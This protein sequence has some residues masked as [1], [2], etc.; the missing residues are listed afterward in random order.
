MF[1]GESNSV[2]VRR[3]VSR[4]HVKGCCMFISQLGDSDSR[5]LGRKQV[6]NPEALSQESL[7]EG[8]HAPVTQ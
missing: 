3:I 7:R 6:P 5:S 8:S 1:W 4:F 2:K